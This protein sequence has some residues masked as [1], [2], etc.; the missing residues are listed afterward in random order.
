MRCSVRKP[1]P[2]LELLFL[3][4]PPRSCHSRL[5]LL[6]K[7]LPH[8]GEQEEVLLSKSPRPSYHLFGRFEE[9]KLR[10]LGTFRDMLGGSW[11]YNRIKT[12][13][14]AQYFLGGFSWLQ[15]LNNHQLL[16]RLVNSVRTFYLFAGI[17]LMICKLP[18]LS[19]LSMLCCCF[20]LFVLKAG[21]GGF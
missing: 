8:K 9:K 5:L 17:D 4:P 6:R 10:D 16:D 20:C 2:P 18:K 15:S 13:S 14:V 11:Y 7:V 3:P 19:M 12:G 1:P 21:Q